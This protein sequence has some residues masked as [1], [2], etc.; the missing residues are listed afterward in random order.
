LIPFIHNAAIF[1]VTR[2]QA[3]KTPEGIETV[4]ATNHR[5]PVLFT[6][7]LLDKLRQSDNGR[8]I[9]ILSKG[10]LAKPFLKVD[11]HDPEYDNKR[12]NAVHAYYQSKLAQEL[13][14]YWIAEKLKDTHITASCIRVPAVKIDIS[15]HPE[16]SRFLKWVYSQKAKRSIEPGEMAETYT[17]LASSDKVGRL[18]GKCFNGNKLEV[19]SGRYTKDVNTIVAV[20]KL[21]QSYIPEIGE[22]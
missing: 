4:W 12:Y 6:T 9:T 13:Y 14:A 7:L 19:D 1:D 17:Y 10:L 8:I 11:L 3:E 22:V 5:E 18:T 21:T 2:K 20:M 15:R 16:L